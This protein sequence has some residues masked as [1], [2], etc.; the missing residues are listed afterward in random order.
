MPKDTC[1]YPKN[2]NYHTK[3]SKIIFLKNSYGL[4]H[5]FCIKYLYDYTNKKPYDPFLYF[6]Y[7]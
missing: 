4:I 6:I 3:I 5:D 2:T 1:S 7:L